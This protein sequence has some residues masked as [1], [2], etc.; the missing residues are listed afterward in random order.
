MRARRYP[1]LSYKLKAQICISL[2]LILLYF[3]ERLYIIH[4]SL[5]VLILIILTYS[6]FILTVGRRKSMCTEAALLHMH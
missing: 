6:S 2:K 1:Q 3:P 5:E 4:I